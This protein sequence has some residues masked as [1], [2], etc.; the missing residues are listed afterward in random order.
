MELELRLS[1]VDLY[2]WSDILDDREP[3]EELS[4]VA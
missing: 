4:S 1:G 2:E 3:Y